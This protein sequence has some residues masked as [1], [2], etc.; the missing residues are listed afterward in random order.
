MEAEKGGEKG[1]REWRGKGRRGGREGLERRYGGK[2]GKK[3]G[4]EGRG[5]RDGEKGGRQR[6]LFLYILEPI[7]V[8][9][10]ISDL[11]QRSA[12][13]AKNSAYCS[14]YSRKT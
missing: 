7:I 10:I 2:V 5:K 8:N 13:D 6:K 12:L 1:G 3:I 14:A 4:R 11:K 9:Y